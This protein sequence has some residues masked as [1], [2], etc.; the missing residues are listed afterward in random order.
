MNAALRA[1]RSAFFGVGLMSGLLNLLYLTGSFF[2]LEVYDRVIPSRSVPTLVGLGL[3]A[4][5]L[6]AFQGSLEGLRGRILARIGACLDE[7]LAA[8]VFGLVVRLPLLGSKPGDGLLPLRDLD[9][10]RAFLS[11]AGPAALFDLPWMPLYLV[12][13]LPVPPSDRRRRARRGR[14]AGVDH[15][16]HRP[17]HAAAAKAASGHGCDRHAL[18]EA[19]PAQR[20]GGGGAGHAAPADASLGSPMPTTCRRSNELPMRPEA[21]GPLSKVVPHGPAIG[22]ARASA[23]GW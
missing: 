11:G 5:A 6:Y 20:R 22:R 2:M 1:C 12:H 18:A 16:D 9:Q 15:P 8:R 23:L 4:L 14:G 13:L 7:R 3:L 19:A 10:I 17:P 21:S